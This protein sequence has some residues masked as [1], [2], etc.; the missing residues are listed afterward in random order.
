MAGYHLVQVGADTTIANNGFAT[1]TYGCDNFES[2]LLDIAKTG[3]G[4]TTATSPDSIYITIQ[5]GTETIAN[6]VPLSAFA[7]LN[8][9]LSG[10]GIT[11]AW[12]AGTGNTGKAFLEI[13]TGCHYL[14]K[15]AELQVSIANSSGGGLLCKVYSKV[16]G[17]STPSPKK[18]L[19]RTDNAFM[20]PLVESLYAF[21]TDGTHNMTAEDGNCT[22]QYG[23]E[24]VLVPYKAGATLVNADSVGDDEIQN[25]ALIYDGIPRSM[26]IN[27]SETAGTIAFL[28]EVKEV[29]SVVQVQKARKWIPNKFKSLSKKERVVLAQ[30]H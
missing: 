2:V 26:Q 19:W 7:S 3:G 8:Q 12:P 11:Q 4:T 27:T 20:L 23:T 10:T 1:L 18:W 22:L 21:D 29:A 17:I 14:D 9:F 5:A 16:N 6:R 25:M 24:N 30:G 28:A 15:G 13:D